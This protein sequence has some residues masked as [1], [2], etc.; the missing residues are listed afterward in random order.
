MEIGRKFGGGIAKM[1]MWRGVLGVE[2]IA[3]LAK[4]AH[5]RVVVE[6]AKKK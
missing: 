2:E 3:A 5:G 1:Q 6:D 4:A